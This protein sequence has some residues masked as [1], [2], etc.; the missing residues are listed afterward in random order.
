MYIATIN[1]HHGETTILATLDAQ[2]V[3]DALIDSGFDL[4]L[5]DITRLPPE[6]IDFMEDVRGTYAY[7]VW[8]KSEFEI[9][10]ANPLSQYPEFWSNNGEQQ[11]LWFAGE[12]A[13]FTLRQVG[14]AYGVC[15][16]FHGES[17]FKP[18]YEFVSEDMAYQFMENFKEI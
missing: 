12:H 4:T 1:H 8:R 15:L 7:V 3:L 13:S 6:Y 9:V 2:K 10:P 18:T 5:R 16:G 17:S 11:F 14:G